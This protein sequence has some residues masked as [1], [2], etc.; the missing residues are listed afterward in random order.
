MIKILVL[1]PN[2]TLL[3]LSVYYHFFI[4]QHTYH[5]VNISVEYS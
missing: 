3:Y 2:H 4:N 1:S 5:L